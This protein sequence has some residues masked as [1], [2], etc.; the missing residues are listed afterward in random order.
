MR[1]DAYP[2]ESPGS[3]ASSRS[4]AQTLTQVT[5]HQ[6]LTATQNTSDESFRVDRKELQ[7]VSFVGLILKAETSETV[8]S[9][10]IDDG[11][12]TIQVKYWID[13]EIPTTQS[14]REGFYVRVFGHL[15][16]FTERSVVAFKL[17]DIPDLNEITYHFLEVL[18]LHLQQTRGGG[19]AAAQTV[20]HYDQTAGAHPA[21][22]QPLGP[23][24]NYGYSDDELAHHIMRLV[25]GVLDPSGA[26]R[27]YIIAAT[28]TAG[29]SEHAVQDAI[30]YLAGNG[31]LFNTID[32]FHYNAAAL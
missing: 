15:R 17:M 21:P 19:A 11:T 13:R 2:T 9:Y 23:V 26:S 6:L 22:L 16:S 32:D 30:E 12:G 24:A 14:W 29:Y 25:T 20:V 1:T 4:S 8:L 10:E 3:S 7:Q 27:S 31:F 18:A 28:K 5:I